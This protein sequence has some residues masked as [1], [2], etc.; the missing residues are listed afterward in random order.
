M[1]FKLLVVDPTMGLK[2]VSRQAV[3]AQVRGHPRTCSLWKGTSCRP[4]A[5][6]R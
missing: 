6:P 4:P 1:F 5:A 2:K 3:F